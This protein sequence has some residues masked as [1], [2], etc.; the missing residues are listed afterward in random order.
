MSRSSDRGLAEPVAALVALVALGAGLTVYTGVLHEA[1]TAGGNGRPAADAL[2]R[3]HDATA[4][5]GPL[6]PGDLSVPADAAGET[7]VVRASL[8]TNERRWTAGDPRPA[9]G[10]APS[11]AARR[12]VPIRTAPGE[13]S[14][15]TLRVEVWT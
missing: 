7:W 11:H 5:E 8:S 3:I 4:S 9:D 10:G 1:D 6:R 12:S 14:P 15:G 13:S 2:D